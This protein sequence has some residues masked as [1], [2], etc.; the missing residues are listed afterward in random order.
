MVPDLLPVALTFLE[1]RTGHALLFSYQRF[2]VRLELRFLHARL[3]NHMNF[4]Q[5]QALRVLEISVMKVEGQLSPGSQ[6]H[7]TTF[8]VNV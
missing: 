7:K 1:Q 5:K 8:E 4:Y 6:D 2:L 3:P